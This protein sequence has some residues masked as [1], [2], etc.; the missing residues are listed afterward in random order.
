MIELKDIEITIEG[1]KI[2][3]IENYYDLTSGCNV[4]KIS[5]D[6]GGLSFESNV[7]LRDI[8]DGFIYVT[9]I[10]KYHTLKITTAYQEYLFDSKGEIFRDSPGLP[11]C[12][13]K[14]YPIRNNVISNFNV[15]KNK[16]AFF[17]APF[18][19]LFPR[20]TAIDYQVK[21]ETWI[22]Y[23]K[24]SKHNLDLKPILKFDWELE[25]TAN[26]KNEIWVI[27]NSNYSSVDNIRNSIHYFNHTDKPLMPCDLRDLGNTVKEFSLQYDELKKNNS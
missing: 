11:G 21:F 13:F 8:D 14:I 4:Y 10:C 27:N 9:Q 5:P 3:P 2:L 12:H 18:K 20:W 24:T 23:S 6:D 26:Q 17:D 22:Q 16:I 15:V 7:I 19:E 25:A 1:L